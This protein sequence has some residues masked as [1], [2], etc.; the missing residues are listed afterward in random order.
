MCIPPLRMLLR[1]EVSRKRLFKRRLIIDEARL[2]MFRI[3]KLKGMNKTS[4]LSYRFGPVVDKYF[5]FY[6]M[7][8]LILVEV[9][10][11]IGRRCVELSVIAI[12]G[13]MR[14]QPSIGWY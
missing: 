13:S 10:L 2:L 9:L 11:T 4:R 5:R 12:Q 8:M 6:Q 1:P 3:R 14:L 7:A